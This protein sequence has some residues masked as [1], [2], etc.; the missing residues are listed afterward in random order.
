MLATIPY[1][2]PP[3]L[4]GGQAGALLC[5]L[6]LLIAGLCLIGTAAKYRR[7]VAIAPGDILPAIWIA[8][9][10]FAKAVAISDY[11]RDVQAGT[12]MLN[13]SD[14]IWRH[15]L[16]PTTREIGFIMGSNRESV[17]N[18]SSLMNG[19]VLNK[20]NIHDDG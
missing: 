5:V 3:V 14:G 18:D 2:T 19:S 4:L 11:P 17:N 9:A 12:S 13:V 8:D 1:L 10:S 15:W 16:T 7:I 20:S 6:V